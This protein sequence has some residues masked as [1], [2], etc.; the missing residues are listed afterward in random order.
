M[1][2][3]REDNI[4]SMEDG[5]GPYG[6]CTE[7]FSIG[8]QDLHSSLE[9]RDSMRSGLRYGMLSLCSFETIRREILLENSN[10]FAWIPVRV[11]KR[12]PLVLQDVGSNFDTDEFSP[13]IESVYARLSGGRA[14]ERIVL[15]DVERIALCVVAD[16]VNVPS[17]FLCQM[18]STSFRWSWVRPFTYH[19]Q[20]CALRDWTATFLWTDSHVP[21]LIKFVPTLLSS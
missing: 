19:S 1:W 17:L 9:P 14:M 8:T 20:G 13:L 16:H 7:I 11:L 18:A 3:L 5:A 10:I 6:H 15:S 2:K 21:I 4:W 12:L